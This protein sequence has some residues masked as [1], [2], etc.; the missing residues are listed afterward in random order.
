MI[1]RL[2]FHFSHFFVLNLLIFSA[3]YIYFAVEYPRGFVFYSVVIAWR[4]IVK[5]LYNFLLVSVLTYFLAYVT[6]IVKYTIEDKLFRFVGY[7]REIFKLFLI[8]AMVSFVEFFLFYEGR[9]GRLFYVYLFVLYSM[10]YYIYRLLRSRKG[11]RSL[12]WMAAVPAEAVFKKYIKKPGNFRVYTEDAPPGE[13]GPDIHVVYQDGSIDEHTSEQLIKNKLAGYTVVELVELVEKES[14]KIPLD[15]VNIHWFLEKFDVVDRNYFRSSR[16]FNIFMSLALLVLFFPPGILIALVHRC[17]SK[18]SIFFVQPRVG[19][20]GRRFKLL[21]FRTMVT[22]AEQYG[23]QFAEKND[24]RITPLGKFMRRFRL[25]EI[26]QFINIL[27]GDMSM[28]GPRPE[29]EVFIEALAKDIPY[30]K[31]RLLVPPGLTGWGQIN[32]VY[33]GN[34]IED[35]KEKLEYDLYYI[36]NRSLAM[37]LLI[38]LRTVKTIIQGK[39]E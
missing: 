35:H 10:Y 21:K 16:W 25:D 32:G 1:K 33:A 7:G 15:Y 22:E 29:R 3:M 26:P 4:F 14:G 28:V 2:L 12:L 13:P 8:L 36:K 9:I 20:H 27:K 6:G 18:G 5:T 37:D 34:D 38:L 23:A 17:F 39:G 19:L 30:Y 31:L 11:P 24:W